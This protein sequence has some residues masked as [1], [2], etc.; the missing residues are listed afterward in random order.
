MIAMRIV[1]TSILLVL[2]LLIH[3]QEMK[4]FR[5]DG[6]KISIDYPATWVYL[7]NSSTVFILIRPLEQQGQSFRE[8]V[9]LIIDNA[10]RLPLA[11]YVRLSKTQLNQQLAGFKEVSKDEV[12]IN[13]E[14]CIRIIYQ[15]T[16][17]NLNLIIAC[18]F[19]PFKGNIYQLT[20]SSTQS[21]FNIYFPT[22]E[23]MV[24]TFKLGK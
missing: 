23:K 9:N 11:E 7:D 19:I 6:K 22:F 21:N 5:L 24:N 15:H 18:Y 10:Q 12:I 2:N 20:C 3:A 8:N 4:T 13:D 1:L 14:E 17:S 16:A